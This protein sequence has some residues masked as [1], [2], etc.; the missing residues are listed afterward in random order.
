M[1][2]LSKDNGERNDRSGDRSEDENGRDDNHDKRNDD[3]SGRAEF[4]ISRYFEGPIPPPET[5]AK[6]E[7][8]KPGLADR[9]VSM[10]ERDLESRHR[11]RRLQR[12]ISFCVLVLLIGVA[13][14]ALTIAL[15]TI[16]YIFAELPA[17][18]MVLTGTVARGF[19]T[20]H[21][22]RMERER[23]L[24]SQEHESEQHDLDIQIRREQHELD[25]EIKRERH[26]RALEAGEERLAL[27]DSTE[28]DDANLAG[29]QDVEDDDDAMTSAT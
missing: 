8:I 15:P 3:S 14:L 6:Y 26:I 12:L 23:H 2:R 13:A 25:L 21:K 5:L 29:D 28:E 16:V 11:D 22:I 10:A 1:T 7:E 19:Q 9:L 4:R 24:L 17:V 20:V 18:A 27:P